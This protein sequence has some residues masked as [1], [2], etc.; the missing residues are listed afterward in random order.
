MGFGGLQRVKFKFVIPHVQVSIKMLQLV[1]KTGSGQSKSPVGCQIKRDLENGRTA[2]SMSD[3]T[4]SPLPV[5]SALLLFTSIN[6]F[7]KKE[8]LWESASLHQKPKTVSALLSFMTEQSLSSFS[9]NAIPHSFRSCDFCLCWLS[10][11]SN[12]TSYGS[13][14]SVTRYQ[15]LGLSQTN[16]LG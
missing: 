1:N 2:C 16:G 5:F 3:A 13:V 9:I 12:D 15:S 14:S 11:L 10:H 8:H 6:P 4:Q 7:G